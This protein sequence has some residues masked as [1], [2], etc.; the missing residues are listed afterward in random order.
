M[1]LWI[2]STYCNMYFRCQHLKEERSFFTLGLWF[3]Y[4]FGECWCSYELRQNVNLLRGNGIASIFEWMLYSLIQNT[5]GEL[6]ISLICLS[7][8]FWPPW[9]IGTWSSPA[10]DQNHSFD[11][12]H[13]CGNAGSLTH[14]AGARYQT[15]ILSLQR[16]L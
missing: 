15:C 2:L 9:G 1:F 13:R 14:H 7:F 6:T 12:G 11:L 5:S 16:H 8:F 3:I 4:L 10:R